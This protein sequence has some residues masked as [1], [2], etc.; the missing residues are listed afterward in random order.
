MLTGRAFQAQTG[1]LRGINATT[2]VGCVPKAAGTTC[3]VTLALNSPI[4]E[5]FLTWDTF[6]TA[7]DAPPAGFIGNFETCRASPPSGEMT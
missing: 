7:V 6:G 4:L 2:D 5:R 3:D 1:G